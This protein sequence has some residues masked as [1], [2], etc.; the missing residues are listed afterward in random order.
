MVLLPPRS[1]FMGKRLLRAGDGICAILPDSAIPGVRPLRRGQVHGQ[2]AGR[3]VHVPR[4]PRKECWLRHPSF[5]QDS[6]GAG[7]FGVSDGVFHWSWLG[8]VVH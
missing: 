6:A 5:R 4:D 1:L 8:P 3:V 2:G 7:Y